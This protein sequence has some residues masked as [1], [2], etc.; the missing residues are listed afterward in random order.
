MQVFLRRI[1]SDRSRVGKYSTKHPLFHI[2]NR[3]IRVS[4]GIISEFNAERSGNSGAVY[5]ARKVQLLCVNR[6]NRRDKPEE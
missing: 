3:V 6:A 2:F 4:E 5:S 1:V